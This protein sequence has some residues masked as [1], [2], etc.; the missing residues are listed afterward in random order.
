MPKVEAARREVH[1][2]IGLG[3]LELAAAGEG[4]DGATREISVVGCTAHTATRQRLH[5][6]G[7]NESGSRHGVVGGARRQDEALGP[8]RKVGS[9]SATLLGVRSQEPA[10]RNRQW[11]RLTP[12]ASLVLQEAWCEGGRLEVGKAC[13]LTEGSWKSSAA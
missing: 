10:I 3:V 6:T 13:G 4:V 9:D 2:R 5:T 8:P 1:H 7:S 12:G 11:S